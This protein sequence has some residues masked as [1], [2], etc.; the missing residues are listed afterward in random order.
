MGERGGKQKNKHERIF[1]YVCV[2]WI[3]VFFVLLDLTKGMQGKNGE[4]EEDTFLETSGLS[5]MSLVREKKELV[6]LLLLPC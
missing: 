6:L 4:E 2:T 3:I 5:R 1:T